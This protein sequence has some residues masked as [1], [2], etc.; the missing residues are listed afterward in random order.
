[1][2]LNNNDQDID[3]NGLEELRFILFDLLYI[4]YKIILLSPSFWVNSPPI[5]CCLD[6]LSLENSS[7]QD[8]HF[9]YFLSLCFSWV[10]LSH[11][12]HPFIMIRFFLTLSENFPIPFIHILL[13]PT[14]NSPWCLRK[15]T[16]RC[17]IQNLK[18]EFHKGVI[19]FWIF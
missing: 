2:D 5:L 11:S 8:P 19:H 14:S 15:K 9:W 12:L 4:L 18:G 6:C 16:A 10:Y 17:F 13:G 3:Y 7:W 1:M